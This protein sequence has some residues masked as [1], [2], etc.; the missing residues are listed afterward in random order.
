MH[1]KQSRWPITLAAL[2]ACACSG[3]RGA[4]NEKQ[5]TS[6]LVALLPP[7]HTLANAATAVASCP[8]VESLRAA[9]RKEPG[10]SPT[11]DLSLMTDSELRVVVD[12]YLSKHAFDRGSNSEEE[13]PDDVVAGMLPILYEQAINQGYVAS[14]RG[15]SRNRLGQSL[16]LRGTLM[17]LARIHDEIGGAIFEQALASTECSNATKLLTAGALA[18]AEEPFPAI[19]VAAIAESDTDSAVRRRAIETLG[20]ASDLDPILPTILRAIADADKDMRVAALR[21]LRVA[22]PKEVPVSVASEVLPMLRPLLSGEPN[23]DEWARAVSVAGAIESRESAALLAK[24][25]QKALNAPNNKRF[26]SQA[27]R[28]FRKAADEGSAYSQGEAGPDRYRL[29]ASELLNAW[30]QSVAMKKGETAAPTAPG[31]R[32]SIPANGEICPSPPPMDRTNALP[33]KWWTR[34]APCSDGGNLGGNPPPDGLSVQ[35]PTDVKGGGAYATW[36]DNGTLATQGRR[37]RHSHSSDGSGQGGV[38]NEPKDVGLHTRWAKDGTKILEQNGN[39][40]TK[41]GAGGTKSSEKFGD[42]TVYYNGFGVKDRET[43][44]TD[45]GDRRLS[46]FYSTGVKSRETL[47]NSGGVK[48]QRYWNATGQLAKLVH[49]DK[50]TARDT[51]EYEDG[52]RVKHVIHT[53]E[54]GFSTGSIT[55]S[56]DTK[57]SLTSTRTCT[58]S[59]ANPRSVCET[60]PKPAAP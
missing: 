15:Q 33:A 8:P 18:S 27:V 48:E 56:F 24:A 7:G 50:G 37:T 40:T 11:T 58:R 41:W 49:Y 23:S 38:G 29:E 2:L 17:L 10:G 39:R 32:T 21:A 30:N 12:A 54:S 13:R 1:G 51:T 9:P 34:Q 6:S 26:L 46:R 20:F 16:N 31:E 45:S 52:Q 5:S 14:E 47:S 4:E 19:L 43:Q 53:M 55:K 28:A 60:V 22:L 42:C 25:L 57:G 36:H 44:T 59:R 3:E 35:C